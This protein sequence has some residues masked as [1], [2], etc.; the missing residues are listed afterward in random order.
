MIML[1]SAACDVLSSVHGKSPLPLTFV[2]VPL[3]SPEACSSASGSLLV[4]TRPG[5]ADALQVAVS[6][7]PSPLNS[8]VGPL[9]DGSWKNSFV[10]VSPS[11][12]VADGL[13]A[14]AGPVGPVGPAPRRVVRTLGLIC[15]VE[16]IL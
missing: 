16:L 9:L 10:S 1:P 3:T 5:V 13:G 11:R 8:V 12:L 7:R 4:A 6:V 14:P 15:L 2:N